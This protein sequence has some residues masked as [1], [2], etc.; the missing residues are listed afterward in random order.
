MVSPEFPRPLLSLVAL[1]PDPEDE[2]PTPQHENEEKYC[3]RLK[4]GS[5]FHL[6]PVKGSLLSSFLSEKEL[7]G[8]IW[9]FTEY[10]RT[11]GRWTLFQQE[12][13]YETSRVNRPANRGFIHDQAAKRNGEK[14][15]D[16]DD[17]Y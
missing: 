8:W 10:K 2:R 5:S 3:D 14:E 4:S 9:L 15:Y 1:R 12:I 13:V 6:P 11:V 17:I 16:K 7:K